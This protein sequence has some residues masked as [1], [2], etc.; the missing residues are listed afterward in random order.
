M[1]VGLDPVFFAM[2]TESGIVEATPLLEEKTSTIMQAFVK[3]SSRNV[4]GDFGAP[5]VCASK[6]HFFLDITFY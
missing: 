3:I 1:C 2:L 6:H 5:V 4:S